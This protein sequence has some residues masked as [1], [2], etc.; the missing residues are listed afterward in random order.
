MK[1]PAEQVATAQA[2]LLENLSPG[3]RLYLINRRVTASGR[4]RFVSPLMISADGSPRY[5]SWHVACLLGMSYEPG[6]MHDSIRINA[7]GLD[8]GTYLT[9]KLSGSLGFGVSHQWL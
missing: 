3:C 5:F 6:G 2:T 1:Y 4:T 8:V 7:L 9:Q